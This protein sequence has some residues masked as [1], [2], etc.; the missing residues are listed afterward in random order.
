MSTF[1][2]AAVLADSNPNVATLST[3]VT[4]KREIII[5][6]NMFRCEG[7]TCV[8]VARAADADTVSTC[9]TLTLK[10]GSVSAYV[11]SGKPFDA[12]KLAKCNAHS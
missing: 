12:D 8:L 10:V 9:H 5:G 11:A 1:L 6:A 4:A 3:P 7:T 2:A